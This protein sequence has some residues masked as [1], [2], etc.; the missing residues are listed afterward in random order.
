MRADIRRWLPALIAGALTALPGCAEVGGGQAAPHRAGALSPTRVQLEQLLAAVRVVAAWGHPG[1]YERG[2]K[3][4]QRCV[5]GQSWTADHDGPGG[6]DGC[7]TRII[8]TVQG[9]AA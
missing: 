4:G 9:G 5:F 2:C 7:D 1:G 3:E 8:C 6:H